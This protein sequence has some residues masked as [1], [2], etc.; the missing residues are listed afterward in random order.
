MS[1]NQHGLFATD[2]RRVSLTTKIRLAIRAAIQRYVDRDAAKWLDTPAGCCTCGTG[3]PYYTGRKPSVTRYLYVDATG[4]GNV[5]DWSSC[6]AHKLDE[7]A[8]VVDYGSDVKVTFRQ[9]ESDAAEALATGR[10]CFRA[11]CHANQ[12]G[13]VRMHTHPTPKAR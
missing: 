1:Q 11:D 2:P 3:G 13:T 5:P 12:P 10:L 6:S 8:P 9:T 4:C 7:L